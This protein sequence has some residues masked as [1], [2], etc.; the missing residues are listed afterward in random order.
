ADRAEEGLRPTEGLDVR[1]LLE[2]PD[3]VDVQGRGGDRPGLD[4]PEQDPAPG[5]A[6]GEQLD[7]LRSQFRLESRI[8]GDEEDGRPGVAEPAGGAEATSTEVGRGAQRALWGQRNGPQ[9]GRVGGGGEGLDRPEPPG[10]G[11]API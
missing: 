6:L 4:G 11:L 10:L 9:G 8:E 3:L 5:G 2:P 1:R 7:D